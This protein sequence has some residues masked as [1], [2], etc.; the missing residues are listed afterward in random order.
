MDSLAPVGCAPDKLQLVFKNPIRCNSIAPDGSDFIIT[1]TQPV[2]IS[3][4]N[5]NC[6]EGLTNI[7]NI[8]LTSPIVKD[9][10]FQIRL[11]AGSD[12]NTLIDECG[13]QTPAG[14]TLSFQTKDTVSAQFSYTINY[15]CKTD[16]VICAHDGR[17]GVSQWSWTLDNNSIAV[18]APNATVLYASFGEKHISLAVSNGVCRDTASV[19]I[20]LDNEL[21]AA[22]EIPELL[23]PEDEAV[24]KNNSTGKIISWN[25]DFGN[26]I[27]STLQNPSPLHYQPESRDKY[28]RVQLIVQNDLNCFDTVSKQIKI[29]YNC[30]I[31]VPSAFTPNNDGL[32]D[33]LYPLNAYK[34]D[35]LIFNVYN[36]FGQLVFTTRDWTKKWDGRINGEA[37]PSG[38]YVWTLNY[39]ERDTGKK[40]SRKGTTVLIR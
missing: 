33:F 34:A 25:W 35:Q 31:A 40:V 22:F 36:R 4:A 21:K 28:Y 20:V 9:G 24:F 7:V 38:T 14:A 2:T 32:N 13:L 17:N 37:Q 6:N 39:V 8:F 26:G 23:C 16:T 19:S 30:Y 3:A 11:R 29:L 1:G 5:G 18:G 15:G 12:N 27:T 10:S